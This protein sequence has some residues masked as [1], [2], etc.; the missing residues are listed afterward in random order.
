MEA[1][2][3]ESELRMVEASQ[4]SEIP[5]KYWARLDCGHEILC[6]VDVNTNLTKGITPGASVWM[7]CPK[8]S[9]TK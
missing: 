6:S 7:V 8:C 2:F 4:S 5:G 1:D 3:D 9:G